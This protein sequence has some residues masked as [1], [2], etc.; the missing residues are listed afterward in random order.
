MTTAYSWARSPAATCKSCGAAVVWVQTVG[1]RAMPLDAATC[2]PK[3]VEFDP[4]K[5]HISHFATCKDA[6]RWRQPKPAGGR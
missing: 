1:G 6:A 3:A 4:A 2:D 5:G